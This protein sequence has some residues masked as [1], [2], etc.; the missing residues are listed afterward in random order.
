MLLNKQVHIS[1]VHIR[2]EDEL[3]C[4][5]RPFAFGFSI[6]SLSAQVGKI[7]QRWFNLITI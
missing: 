2:Y 6:E 1:D 4:P 5:A 3:S 7:F